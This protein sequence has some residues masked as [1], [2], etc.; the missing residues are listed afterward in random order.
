MTE[1]R[2]E[3]EHTDDDSGKIVVPQIVAIQLPETLRVELQRFLGSSSRSYE[4][5]AYV[6]LL[7]LGLVMAL[8][9]E[10][11]LPPGSPEAEVPADPARLRRIA[12]T[13]WEVLR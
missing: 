1:Y 6:Q 7:S 12:E 3:Q 10:G 11:E 2:A 9:L 5:F 8:E 4:H 13:A